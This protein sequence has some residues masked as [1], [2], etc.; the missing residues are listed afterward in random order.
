MTYGVAVPTEVKG[1]QLKFCA[2][3]VQVGAAIDQEL[4]AIPP[5]VVASVVQRRP[6]GRRNRR[7]KIRKRRQAC[8]FVSLLAKATAVTKILVRRDIF[9]LGRR[10]NGSVHFYKKR[11]KK[12]SIVNLV[13]IYSGSARGC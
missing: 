10:Y 3:L 1:D 12:N 11:K 7:T 9:T 5:I 8:S 13:Y 2:L 6:C 4:R